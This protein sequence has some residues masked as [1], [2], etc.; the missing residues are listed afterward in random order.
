MDINEFIRNSIERNKAEAQIMLHQ[1]QHQQMAKLLKNSGLGKRFQART[2]EWTKLTSENENAVNAARKFADEFPQEQGIMFTGPVGTGKTHLA[3]AIANK[4][5]DKLYTVVF[6]NVTDIITLIKSSYSAKGDM[7]E[8]EIINTITNIDLLVI[9]DLGKEYATENTRM[10]L[11]QIINR[12]YENEKP[13]IVTTNL[14]ADALTVKYGER[15]Q[16]IVSRLT[17]MCTPVVLGGND[18]RIRG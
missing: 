1:K 14:T 7:S 16:P 5:I 6:G 15:G 12:L 17:E 13:V 2:F 8:A 10:L 3:A 9:D 11:Y 18:W 4:L